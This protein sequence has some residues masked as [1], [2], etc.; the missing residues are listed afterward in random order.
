MMSGFFANDYQGARSNFLGVCSDRKYRMKTYKNEACRDSSIELTTDVVRVGPDDATNVLV[1]LSGT[2]GIEGF[3][4]SACQIAAIRLGLFDDLPPHSAVIII[5][6]INPFG[7]AFLRRVTESNV[8]LNRNCVDDFDSQVLK[9][10]NPDY[11]VLDSVLNPETWVSTTPH[12]GFEQIMTFIK[13]HGIERFQAAVSVGQ[14]RN[15][16]GLFYGGAEKTWSRRVLE[17]IIASELETPRKV[18]AIDYHTGLGQPGRGELIC[19][20][21]DASEVFLRARHIFGKSVK[22]TKTVS[23]E[24]KSVSADVAGSVDRLFPSAKEMT[25]VALEFGTLNVLEVLEALRAENWLYHYG[26][27]YNSDVAKQIKSDLRTAFCPDSEE[28]KQSVLHRSAQVLTQA[29]K[30]LAG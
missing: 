20:E 15:P 4:G 27:D 11:L 24:S 26:E 10:F 3:C 7:F 9:D 6:A 30:A 18:V 12:V 5:H 28:W 16:K 17:D 25:Y 22:S 19:I 29:V 23:A 1:L 8:D 13:Q 21:S 14:Y 2:H